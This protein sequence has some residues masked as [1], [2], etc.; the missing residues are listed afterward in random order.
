MLAVRYLFLPIHAEP[1]CFGHT[2]HSTR[3]NQWLDDFAL[4]PTHSVC[5][6]YV[7]TGH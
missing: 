5:Q 3:L 7:D 4:H 2:E 1:F 6:G